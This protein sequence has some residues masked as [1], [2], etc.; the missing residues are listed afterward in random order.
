LDGDF[1]NR[2]EAPPY[3]KVLLSAEREVPLNLSKCA[4]LL[5]GMQV[6]F[7]RGERGGGQDHDQE[8]EQDYDYD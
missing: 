8:Q 7:V 1:I 5:I 3:E 6:D 2:I 4:V